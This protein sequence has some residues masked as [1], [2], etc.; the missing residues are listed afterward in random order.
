MADFDLAIIGSGSGNGLITEKW[1]TRRVALIEGSRFGGT[2]LNTGCIPS[3]MLVY[4][5]GIAETVRGASNFGITAHFGEARWTEIRDR[6]F[7]LIDGVSD[8]GRRHRRDA[9]DVSLFEGTARFEGARSLLVKTARG[10]EHM[11]ASQIVIATGSRPVVPGVFVDAGVPFHTSDTIMRISSLPESMLIVGGGYVAAEF[12]HIFSSLGVQIRIVTRGQ[13]LL[14]GLDRAISQQ[15]TS[16]AKRRWGLFLE[17]DIR[18]A[19]TRS[20]GIEV[21]LEDGTAVAGDVLLVAAGRRPN[22]DDLDLDAA[23]IVVRE[24]GRIDVDDFG[25]T[26]A[27]GVWALGDVSSRYQLK[28]VANAEARTVADN[29]VAARDGGAALTEMPHRAVPAAV[30]TEPQIATIGASGDELTASGCRFVSSTGYLRD[31]A[32]GWASRDE[33]GMCRL[34][35]D[36]KTHLLLGAHILGPE[37]ATLIQPLVTGMSAGIPVTQ[38]ARGQYWIHPA[39][40]ELVE[41]ALLALCDQ[42]SG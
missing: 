40:S 34:Y 27:Q 37:A 17:A 42:F 28:H 20:N 2:C 9:P 24:D 35:A 36:P 19:R 29:I 31:T 33:D 4:T 10:D 5:A 18:A 16:H 25:R 3:K 39:P 41:G 15:F 30:F 22:S 11:T 14:T 21:L 13:A 38:L 8:D 26:A 6:I 7:G 32:Y 12:A 23:G 1:D